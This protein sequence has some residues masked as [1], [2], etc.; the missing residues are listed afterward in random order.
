M[1]AIKPIPS[2]EFTYDEK[3]KTFVAFDSDIRHLVEGRTRGIVIRSDKT[4]DVKEFVFDHTSY[5][6]EGEIVSWVFYNE[7]TG[8]K[9][10]LY[11]D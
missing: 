6:S 1:T 10:R 4:G 2:G 8:T 3:T 7:E 11:N 9:V 5:D